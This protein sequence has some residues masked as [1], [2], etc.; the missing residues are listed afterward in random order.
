MVTLYKPFFDSHTPKGKKY[1]VYVLKNN[2]PHLI[3]FGC[4]T[5]QQYHDKIGR[6]KALDHLDKD[7]RANYLARARGIVN[8]QG[9][10]TY[11]DKNHANYYSINYLW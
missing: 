5:M 3:H 7:R 6:W 1:S 11:K 8:G 10:L 2:K 4:R 9:K